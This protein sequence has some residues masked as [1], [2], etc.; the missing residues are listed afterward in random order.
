METLL[1]ADGDARACQEFV[2]LFVP[3]G[4][5]VIVSGSVVEL[6]GELRGRRNRVLLLGSQLNGLPSGDLIPLLRKCDKEVKIVL[7]TG[8]QPS[9]MQEQIAKNGIIFYG[10]RP[11]DLS[12]R[13]RLLREV[14]R[15]FDQKEGTDHAQ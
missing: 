1:V 14:C 7:T 13:N 12:G 4:F 6:L 10:P 2:D 11:E 15:L 5:H 8:E 3:A 9:G